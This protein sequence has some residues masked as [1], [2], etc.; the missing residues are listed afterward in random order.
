[1]GGEAHAAFTVGALVGLG[2]VA[3]YVRAKS[4]PSLV[5]GLT[6]GA[7]FVGCGALI[8]TSQEF[9]GHAFACALGSVLA[10]SM[11]ARAVKSGKFMPAG[12]VA[13]IGTL[14][15]AYHGPKAAEWRP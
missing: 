4:V 6:F 2:G 9:A 13:S 7:G 14:S 3:G 15:A 12:M 5:A 10:V 1:M 11:G 8:S